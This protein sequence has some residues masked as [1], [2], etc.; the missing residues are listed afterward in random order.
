MIGKLTVEKKIDWV[1]FR[2]RVIGAWDLVQEEKLQV[3]PG[4]LDVTLD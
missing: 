2:K 1:M 4:D 3:V